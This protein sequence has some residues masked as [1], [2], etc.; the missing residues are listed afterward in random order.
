MYTRRGM[1]VGGGGGWVIL[2][3][4]NCHLP[5]KKVAELPIVC[6]SKYESYGVRF[7]YSSSYKYMVQFS[8]LLRC[9]GDKKLSIVQDH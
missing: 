7:L 5:T 1:G 6:P 4:S 2:L 8:C 9:F 3:L